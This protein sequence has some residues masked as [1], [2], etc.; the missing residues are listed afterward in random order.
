MTETLGGWGGQEL[1]LLTRPSR[2]V[3]QKDGI[4]TDF[5]YISTHTPLAGRD[6]LSSLSAGYIKEFLLTRPSR[7]VTSLRPK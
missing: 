3:T 4:E 1:F 6:R 2:G 5:L 7:G